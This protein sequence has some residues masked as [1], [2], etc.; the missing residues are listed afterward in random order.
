M[1]GAARDGA[2][3][4]IA[5]LGNH[6]PRQCGIATFTTDLAEALAAD[7]PARECF[8]VA[9]NDGG[10]RHAYPARVLFEIAD[11][12]LAAYRRAADFLNVNGVDVLSLQHEY[13]IFGGKAGGHVLALLRELRMP[14]VTTLHTVLAQP[15]AAQLHVMREITA[16]SERLVVMTAHG[17]TLLKEVHGVPDEKIDVIPHGIPGPP[18]TG[19]TKDQ[20]GV[21]GRP[22]ILT[23]GLLS[24]DKGIEHVIQALPAILASHPEALYV[25]VGAT[26]PHVKEREGE[27]YRVMLEGLAHRLAVDASIVFHDRFVSADE[28]DDF[29][30]AADIYVTP[31]LKEA[32]ITSGTLARA[33]GAG[34]AII[35]TPYWHARDLLADGRGVLVA[36]ADATAIADAA[37][38]LLD[39]DEERV[40][41][42]AR[43]A[44]YGADMRWPVVARRYLE[45]FERA[46]SDHADRR[47]SGFQAR[48][49]AR[50]RP[51]LPEINLD[52]LRAM[53]DDTGLLQ[54][55]TFNV[56]RYD[57]GY[58]L[59]DNA[60]A[61]LLTA[62]LED[63]GSED[64]K[65]VHALGARYLAFVGYAFNPA[66]R[67]FRNFLGYSRRWSEQQGS[68]DSHARALW[69]LGTLVGRS[70][71]PGRRS[72][73]SQLFHAALPTLDE[74]TS[75]R[76]WAYAMLGIDEYLRAFQGDRAVQAVRRALADRLL[77]RYRDASGSDWP[78]FEDSATYCNARL[79][80]ALLAAGASLD[81]ERM[82]VAGVRS[83]AWLADVQ[84]S[85]D[86]YFAPIGSEGW[87]QRGGVK[88]GFDQQPVE[89]CAMVA[90]CREAERVTGEQ[91]WAGHARRAFAW[92]LGQN[93][94]QQSLYD[95]STGGCR[96]GLHPDR[97]NDNQ[98]AES[99]VSFLL[100]LVEMQLADRS[101]ATL[102]RSR[103]VAS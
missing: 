38:R 59:D 97:M 28:L 61:L 57:D 29:L 26:H 24:P 72:L 65:V 32:Q 39:D 18:R 25:V 64:P 51:D 41:L 22:V 87:Y 37:I 9:M 19:R 68:E 76:A 66:R 101:A 99:T 46:R 81:D 44:A 58:C 96:D 98:G 16:L 31:Y 78:W 1:S 30:S 82:S 90:A 73:G 77:G 89:A 95:P 49:L 45:S 63:A 3:G 33:V 52:H 74:F 10:R 83:L 100:A 27:I 7:A 102:A 75:P 93:Q 15:D 5:L 20:L 35:S 86:G 8:V 103:E 47:R 53:T 62:L 70:A 69:A 71:D 60:R 85:A 43:A 94:L 84:R 88:A 54:H 23:F 21:E 56:P 40:A 92:F 4:K 17:A 55:A 80:Q 13:G 79:P 14:I 67:R 6:L 2:V 12:D 50:R 48:T 36:G 91:R 34:K 11:A 42:G